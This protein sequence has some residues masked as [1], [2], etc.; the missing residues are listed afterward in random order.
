VALYD[1][2]DYNEKLLGNESIIISSAK[3][4]ANNKGV[5]DKFTTRFKKVFLYDS[6]NDINRIL[7]SER[8]DVFYAIKLGVND[9]IVSGVCKT[10]VHTVFAVNEPHGD[11]YFYVSHWLSIAASGGKHPYVP[12]MITLPDAT[13][14]YR[15][16]L[17]IPK[18]AI[19]FGRYGSYDTFDIDF[20]Q[21]AVIEIS[22]KRKDIYF[23]FMN[24]KKFTEGRDNIIFLEGTADA[25]IKANFINTCDALLHA[26]MRGE[27]FGITVGEFS[28]KNKPVLTFA[29]SPERSHMEILGDAAL[30]Y[31][32]YGSVTDLICN[33]KHIYDRNKNY[34]RFSPEFNPRSVMEKLDKILFK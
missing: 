22:E 10:G 34:D 25:G 5:V 19:V 32:D 30:L 16:Y 18:D 1:Y 13:D 28:I 4:P 2:A 9:G 15:D 7:G 26:R 23:I 27:T 3:H 29:N 12:H 17:N 24:T 6:P 33:Y 21:K 20:V 11:V 31:N 14:S 8:A